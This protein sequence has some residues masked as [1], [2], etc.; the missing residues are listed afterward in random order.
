MFLNNFKKAVST[1]KMICKNVPNK[2]KIKNDIIKYRELK[3]REL[4][5]IEI[6]YAAIA[7]PIIS[8]NA[9]PNIR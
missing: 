2:N 3:Y 7:V 5:Y 9:N 6:K 1:Q 8:N 4:K